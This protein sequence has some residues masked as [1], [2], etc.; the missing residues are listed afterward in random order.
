MQRVTRWFYTLSLG[1]AIFLVALSNW[2]NA[3]PV[4]QLSPDS[5]NTGALESR[6]TDRSV[7]GN[8]VNLDGIIFQTWVSER[9]W[10]APPN[11][12]N[13]YTSITAGIRVTNNTQESVRIARA[14]ANSTR[15]R[16]LDNSGHS[17][18]EYHLNRLARTESDYP[19]VAPGDS[20]IFSREGKLYWKRGELVAE[21]GIDDYGNEWF[22][23]NL[24][25][26]AEYSL[27]FVYNEYKLPLDQVFNYLQGWLNQPQPPRKVSET[28]TVL[29][30]N[31]VCSSSPPR[32]VD[33][34]G[35]I[36]NSLNTLPVQ[37]SIVT[38]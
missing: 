25:V 13:V 4:K 36:G 30:S 37:I 34:E 11:A 28:V 6:A 19:L 3:T 5:N 38:Q 24:Q 8:A 16:G 32:M 26:G 35:V 14:S 21:S 12:P 2:S 9:E 1:V 29:E 10:V 23:G 31:D 22:L 27:W 20:I 7:L 17:G 15:L 33:L 18:N